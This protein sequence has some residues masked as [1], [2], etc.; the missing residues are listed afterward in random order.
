MTAHPQARLRRRFVDVDDSQIHVRTADIGQSGTPLVMLH[1]SP[2]SSKQL[3]PLIGRL[4]RGRRVLAPDC[5]GNGDSEPLAAE[6]PEIDELADALLAAISTLCADE[7]P[8][9][10]YG[11]HTG[12]RLACSIA[13]RS[14]ARVRRIVLDGFGLYTTG[15]RDEILSVYAPEQAPDPLGRHLMWGWHFARDQWIW[16]PWFDKRNDKR[17][18][19]DLPPPAFL[20][21]LFVEIMKSLT[22]YHRS[23]R[24]AFRYDMSV[25]VPELTQPTLICA[26]KT[27]M[28][29]TA[30]PR[31]AALLPGAPSALL[32]GTATEQDADETAAAIAGFLDHEPAEGA[33][34]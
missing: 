10:L 33:A 18:S 12:A 30:L 27:D 32:P 9:D 17:V 25:A 16:F 20:H 22:T 2:G 23:Y 5:P 21:D 34:P 31:M 1:A 26:Q 6:E 29:H 13:L 7:Q 19:L 28:I 24:A 4:G 14:P 8:F 11:S 3:E 15:E